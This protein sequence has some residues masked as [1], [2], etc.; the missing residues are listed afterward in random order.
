[1]N[2]I[3]VKKL[4]EKLITSQMHGSGKASHT[5]RSPKRLLSL[6]LCVAFI[7]AVSLTA[8]AASYSKGTGD[9]TI[10]KE[11]THPFNS[12]YQLPDTPEPFEITVTLSGA[13]TANAE[14][15]VS[16]TET[17]QDF[18]KIQTDENGQFTVE[19]GHNELITIFD[20]PAGTVARVE[21]TKTGKGFT[22]IYW[23][24]SEKS[25]KNYGEITVT[26]NKTVSVTVENIHEPR[27]VDNVNI[28]L[29]GKKSI[30]DEETNT[31][32][33]ISSWGEDYFFEI[34]FQRFN[35][36][37]DEWE[38]VCSPAKLSKTHGDTFSFDLSAE[39]YAKPGIYAYQVY[40]IEP[41]ENRVEGII[42]DPVW[43]TFSVYVDDSDMDGTLEIVRVHSEHANKDFGL[44]SNGNYEI[45]NNFTNVKTNSVPAL[46]TADI[47][48]NLINSAGSELVG[49]AG[50]NFGLYT[51]E[52]C[53]IPAVNTDF[54]NDGT[55]DIV[56][57][58][59]ATDSAG[60]GWIDVIFNEIAFENAD[61]YVFYIKEINNGISS[62]N[63]S[64]KVVAVEINLTRTTNSDGTVSNIIAD[65]VVFSDDLIFT[66][67]YSP[68]STQLEI[69]FVTK[70]L[71]GRELLEKE[72]TFEIHETD[73]TTVLKGTNDAQGKVSFD[74]SLK[75]DKVG[76][77][78]Y[79][80][81]E[82]S[83]E[84]N[85]IIVDK[86]AY[87]ITA[88]IAD[89]DGQLT[90]SEV[91]VNATG[92]HIVF[93]NIYDAEYTPDTP[94]NPPTGDVGNPA[95]WFALLLVSGIGIF[96]AAAYGRKKKEDII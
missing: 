7:M 86:S 18:S 70:E 36:E 66:N 32:I 93:H 72:F 69:D 15:T 42:Y 51:D 22:P 92:H 58:R 89:V 20:L 76:A 17:T 31:V 95:I 43:H 49:L 94:D 96:G 21:E 3:T 27:K 10:A 5:N 4:T 64:D 40:E 19:L 28:E 59:V 8:S 68:T 62:M 38:D 29:F 87:R 45:I 48:T 9:L 53:T 41:Q 56:I 2:K 23:N 30:I 67:T 73:G 90:V 47:T 74:G 11:I 83:A 39:N 14:F 77:Y 12:D 81:I 35:S 6:L 46:I 71:V 25:E 16:R 1:M 26:P 78:H 63:Y 91:I 75:F 24:D 50:Y 37:T 60:E 84:G 54:N 88:V 34:A 82:T 13:G 44:N 65:E 52:N 57:D 85:G 80:V 79:T 55:D 33:D 61:H